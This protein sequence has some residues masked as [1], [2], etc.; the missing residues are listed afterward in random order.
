MYPRYYTAILLPA[1]AFPAV[2]LDIPPLV[3]HMW[4]RNIAAWSL[5]LWAMIVNFQNAINPLIWPRDN[6]A[7]WWDGQGLCDIEVRIYLGAIVALPAATA[8]VMRKLARVMDTRNITVATSRKSRMKEGVLEIVWCW[9]FPAFQILTYYIVQPIRYF[10][11]G[12]SGCVVAYDTSWPSAVVSWMWGPITM[13]VSAGYA[14]LL[15][16]RMYLYRKEFPNLLV[17]SSTTKSRFMRLLIMSM[18]LVVFY[19][20]YSFF[21]LWKNIDIISSGYSWNAVHG[22]EWNSVIK[23]PAHGQVRIDKWGQVATAYLAFFIFGTGADAKNTYK[24]ILV[25]VGFGRIFPSLYRQTDSG[26]ST[27][28]RRS[29]RSWVSNAASRARSIFSSKSKTH[30]DI[31]ITSASDHQSFSD[32]R[33]PR[34]GTSGMSATHSLYPTDTQDR[35]LPGQPTA[36]HNIQKRSFLDRLFSRRAHP[37]TI[38]PISFQSDQRHTVNSD[39]LLISPTSTTKSPGVYSHTWVSTSPTASRSQVNEGVHVTQEVRQDT[40][41]NTHHPQKRNKEWWETMDDVGED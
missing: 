15:V 10:I 23:V 5:I 8:M 9:G 27:P 18:F 21:I 29:T 30:A 33:T 12:I 36:S 3:W 26:A 20:P 32:L 2:I 31:T 19:T 14:I 28:S 35:I 16:Y 37:E 4:Q 6:V 1:L 22:P 39:K 7:D 24:K 25:S 40:R 34:S 38:L 11:F 41:T 17:A 13:L